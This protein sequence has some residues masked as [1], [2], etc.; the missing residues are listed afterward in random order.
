MMRKAVL[1]SVLLVL[2][3]MVLGSVFREDVAQAA[4]AIIPV[5]VVNTPAEAVPVREQA[6]SQPVQAQVFGSFVSGD[7]FSSEETVYTVPAGKML[8]IESFTGASIMDA[9]DHLMDA[10]FRVEVSGFLDSFNWYLQPVDEGVAH[11]GARVFRG[12]EQVTAYAGPGT[13]V[14]ATAS[15]RGDALAGTAVLFGLAGHL[16]SAP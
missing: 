15:R 7:N 6:T 13:T 11:T 8:V 14:K 12:S 4:Q 2:C 9:T 16:V 3:S 1:A 5:K 10:V